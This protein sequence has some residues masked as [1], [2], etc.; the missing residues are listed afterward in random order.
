[1]PVL[2]PCPCLPACPQHEEHRP[3]L[4]YLLLMGL[5]RPQDVARFTAED[6]KAAGELRGRLTCELEAGAEHLA[7]YSAHAAADLRVLL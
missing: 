2:T 6:V 4:H 7:A 1:M 3:L 5:E